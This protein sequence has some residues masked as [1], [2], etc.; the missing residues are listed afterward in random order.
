MIGKECLL[1]RL[2]Q[3]KS[4][5]QDV[6]F[7]ESGE[8]ISTLGNN[9]SYAIEF[10][11]LLNM[12]YVGGQDDNAIVV[13]NVK[14]GTAICGSPAGADSALFMQWTRGREDRFVSAGAFHLRVWQVDFRLPKLHPVEAKMVIKLL[15]FSF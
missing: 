6:A 1:H 12:I 7:S 8:F 10:I 14:T 9:S 2:K 3:H 11:S 5:V 15:K 4:K 13:W